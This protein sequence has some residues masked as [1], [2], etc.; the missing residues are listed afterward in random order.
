MEYRHLEYFYTVSKLKNFTQAAKN[1]HVSQPTVTN[2]IN[3]LEEQLGVKLLDRN[4][5]N[6]SLTPQGEIFYKRVGSILAD[7]KT[8][9][10]EVQNYNQKV[11]L[12][13]PPM[14][15]ARIFP[16]IYTEFKKLYPSIEFEVAEKGSIA[17]LK[18][19]ENGELDLGL[20][21]LPE[22]TS[23]LSTLPLM[24]EEIMVCVPPAHRFAKEKA[25]DFEL[26]KNEHFIV[27]SE[28]FIHRQITM[29][30]CES[31]GFTP[32]IVFESH[33]IETAKS[34]VASGLG[35]SLFM[36]LIVA[37]RTDIVHIPFRTPFK[38]D[39]G[40]AWKTNKYLSGNSKQFIKFAEAFFT[41]APL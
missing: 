8:A 6:V 9:M 11:K 31:H 1:L 13:V 36:K 20:I 17:T 41:G 27:L 25:I 14:I 5:K 28:E 16:N 24:Q 7:I 4:T 3:Q 35:I 33:A 34:L 38:I 40:L 18:M 2:A 39:I 29:N 15:G 12:G 21:I 37:Q 26:L 32:H 22:Q 10:E 30:L 23:I 19:L